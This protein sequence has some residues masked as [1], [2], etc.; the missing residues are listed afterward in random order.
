MGLLHHTR[1]LLYLGGG[2]AGLASNKVNLA[3]IVITGKSEDEYTETER[4]IAYIYASVLNL[5]QIDIYDNFSSM[6]GD[7]II[8]TEVF[9]ILNKQYN[10]ILS[11][12]DIFLYP[13]IE[14]I[15]E[16]VDK[17][18]GNTEKV[19]NVEEFDNLI[20]QFEQ[21]DVDIDSVVEFLDNK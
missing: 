7:S 11:I 3:D 4:T 1:R 8:S 20:D 6:G 13:T 10:G 16:Y 9:K 17:L 18:T 19:E 2:E 14:S 12:S 15:A 5:N 21:G